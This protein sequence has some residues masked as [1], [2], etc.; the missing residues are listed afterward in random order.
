[1]A[2]V[3][4]LAAVTMAIMLATGDR[5]PRAPVHVAIEPVARQT[6][7]PY[8]AS[9]AI[10]PDGRYVAYAATDT[11]GT[12][13]VWLRSFDSPTVRFLAPAN[14]VTILFWSPDSRSLGIGG[15][16]PAL[17]TVPVEGGTPTE[18]CATRTSRGASWNQ[19][20][21]II[22]APTP[23]GP[24]YRVAASGGDPVQVTWPDTSRHESGH[25]F[26]CFLPDGRH[27]LYVSM[28][29]GPQGFDIYAGSLGS[30]ETKKILTAQSGVTYAAPGYLL[31][32]RAGKLT[33][34]RFD[35]K[36]LKLVS[37]PV[38][39]VEAPPGSDLDAEPI[40]SASN[41]GRLVVLDNPPPDTKLAWLD[42][43]GVL[44]GTLSLPTGPWE[45]ALLSPDDR[46][47]VVA[48]NSDLW[49][50]DL[51][52]SLPVR[53]T[54]DSGYETAPVWS[55]D[56][57]K[58]AYTRGGRGRE[59]IAVMNSDGSGEPTVLRTT[60]H[61]FKNASDWSG[62]GLILSA[63]DSKTRR[64]VLLAPYPGGGAVRPL[65]RTEFGEFFGRVSPDGRWLAYFSNEAGPLDVYLQSFPDPG[66]KTRVTNGG[67]VYMWWMP[68]GDELCYRTAD[69]TKM[70]SVKLTRN[71]ANLDVGEPR[72]LF[73]YPPDVEWSDF[74]HD[75]Q[76]LLVTISSE[77]T[78]NRRGRVILN[79]TGMLRR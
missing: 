43:A 76:R 68:G 14:G 16:G 26:P 39:L 57:S 32:R 53:L 70:M 18:V 60:D 58:I 75:G 4:I 61:L 20:G 69:R 38:P 52:R 13:G 35:A 73:R 41:D 62:A 7:T 24:L 45:R 54:S 55:P 77:G 11:N 21:V 72:L 2:A 12:P 36:G 40:A 67:A 66:H 19:G 44:G 3:A 49:R 34:Q 22:F 42:R 51:A 30:R 71:G 48:N 10:S 17:V 79:W 47:A 37:E 8:A 33:A 5:R 23:Q 50:I 9:M 46:Y 59:E 1:M 28:P 74:T 6:L 65:A 29:S 31:F 25:R 56:G 78:R 15:L 63:I 64:D 27:F